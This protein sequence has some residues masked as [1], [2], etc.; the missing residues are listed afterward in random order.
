[1]Q[2]SVAWECLHECVGGHVISWDVVYVDQSTLDGMAYKMVLN[3]D[4]F[5]PWVIFIILGDGDSERLSR[6]IVSGFT[7][8]QATSAVR[9][10]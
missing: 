7:S 9:N 3:V 2:D 8:G 5:G 10:M 4:V 6:W 1:M